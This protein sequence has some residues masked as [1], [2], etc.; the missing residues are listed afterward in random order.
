MG[1][2]AFSYPS[3]TSP[4]LASSGLATKVLVQPARVGAASHVL[5]DAV[6]G[7][8]DGV[9]VEPGR[10]V[11]GRRVGRG[12]SSSSSARL[13]HRNS[14]TSAWCSVA[15]PIPTSSSRPRGNAS[16]P[17]RP[18]KPARSSHGDAPSRSFRLRA[19]PWWRCGETA[20]VDYGRPELQFLRSLIGLGW[21]GG[22]AAMARLGPN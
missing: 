13:A 3:T 11:A 14:T 17:S 8:R 20:E 5:Q 10:A 15:V 16:R 12:R 22:P 7:V 4:Y 9:E 19:P 18:L 1:L 2:K 6:A 21:R